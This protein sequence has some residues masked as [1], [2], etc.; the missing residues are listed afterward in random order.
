M[1]AK[2]RRP[3]TIQALTEKIMKKNPQ[4][5]AKQIAEAVAK[6]RGIEWNGQPMSGSMMQKAIKSLGIVRENT[7]P[8]RGGAKKGY[9]KR[10]KMYFEILEINRAAITPEKLAG[11]QL[12]FDTA[13]QHGGPKV[14]WFA[15]DEI[16]IFMAEGK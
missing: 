3:G 12:G 8:S 5:T 11:I 13:E 1:K 9:G 16:I 15:K 7:M 2:K 6:V 14:V 4:G 10:K